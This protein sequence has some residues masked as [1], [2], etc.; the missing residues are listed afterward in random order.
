[1]KKCQI[2]EE[3]VSQRTTI[4]RHPER[5]VPGEEQEI[6]AGGLV[7]HVGF[8]QGDQPFV[9]P[10]IYQYDPARPDKLYLHGSHA[11][12]TIKHLADGAPVCVTVTTVRG[13]VYSR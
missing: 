9:I 5:A 2:K 11:S 12:R 4:K 8:S 1:M 7:A 10:M 6:L 13:L 3:F